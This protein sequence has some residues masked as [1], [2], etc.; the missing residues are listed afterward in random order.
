MIKEDIVIF[1][2]LNYVFIIDGIRLIK[3]DKKVYCYVD[4]DDLE[5]VLKKLMNYYMCLIVMDGVF[6]MDGN[7]VFFF[8]IVK[9]VEVYD[10]FVMVDDVYVFGVFGKNGRGMV[11][12]F[13]FDG[14]VYI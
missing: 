12:Y 8:D 4:M 7:I 14:R 13:G 5:R 1:D 10:V 3:V 9:F 2:E 11:N 6:L